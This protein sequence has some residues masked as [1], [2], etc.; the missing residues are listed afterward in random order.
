VER[1]SEHPLAHAIV[2]AANE[3]GLAVPAVQ[4][5]DSPVGKGVVGTVEGRSIAIGNASFLRELG[6]VT[7]ALEQE[8]E[9]QRGDGAT[10]ILVAADGEPIGVIAIADPVKAS[11]AEAL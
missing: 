8:A 11:A 7:D 1:A 4:G 6:I 2:E 3:R 10:A 5:F 9:R